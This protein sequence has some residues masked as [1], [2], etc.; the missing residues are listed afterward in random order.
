MNYTYIKKLTKTA[1]VLKSH[2][3]ILKK[4]TLHKILITYLTSKFFLISLNKLLKTEKDVLINIV[5]LRKISYHMQSM[6]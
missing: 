4:K 1:V 6:M 2:R 5:I 3:H